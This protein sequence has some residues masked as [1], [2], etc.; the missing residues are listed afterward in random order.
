MCSHSLI[1]TEVDLPFAHRVRVRIPDGNLDG[2]FEG[3]RIGLQPEQSTLVHMEF[4][5]SCGVQVGKVN[6]PVIKT[7]AAPFTGG[8]LLGGI[9]QG[10]IVPEA[11]DHMEALVQQRHNECLLG[12]ES[13]RD[14]KLGNGLKPV[15]HG[16]Q[17][18]PIP[19]HQVVV[20]LLKGLGV[21]RLNGTEGHTFV[22]LNVDQANAKQLK[23]TLHCSRRSRP[24]LPEPGC[25]VPSLWDKARVH[26]NGSEL[27]RT[28]LVRN[29]QVERKPV[30]VIPG[31]GVPVGL[32]GELAVPSH[33]QEVDLV[34]YRHEE[35]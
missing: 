19:V 1:G 4:N 26:R 35:F 32:F 20:H 28:H 30:E 11:A 14:K 8:L 15:L 2:A 6:L 10:G 17:K 33:L 29:E 34:G 25:L 7:G 5:T 22:I 16:Y 21:G 12:K 24:V 13:I 23:A 18:F 31:E 9:P 3:L 27:S